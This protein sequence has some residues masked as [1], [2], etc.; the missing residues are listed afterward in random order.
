MLLH[1][2]HHDASTSTS[3]DTCRRRFADPAGSS[4][5]KS[6]QKDR[7][8]CSSDGGHGHCSRRVSWPSRPARSSAVT[9]IAVAG[10]QIPRSHRQDAAAAARRA[11]RA[12][13]VPLEGVKFDNGGDEASNATLDEL[14]L[15]R[16][17]TRLTMSW[18]VAAEA[19][20]TPDRPADGAG[21]P[22][23]LRRRD[24]A[25]TFRY[26]AI[27][28]YLLVSA[29][30]GGARP[31]AP[32]PAREDGRPLL[33]RP[34]LIPGE[35][36]CFAQVDGVLGAPLENDRA[37]R[38][39]ATTRP[40]PR[41]R[42]PRSAH[43]GLRR[44]T[45]AIREPRQPSSAR[46][47]ASRPRPPK[48]PPPRRPRRRRPPRR[49]PSY[50][51]PPSRRRPPSAPVEVE[52]AVAVAGVTVVPSAAGDRSAHRRARAARHVPDRARRGARCWSCGPRPGA[53]TTS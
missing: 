45:G 5:N 29:S 32:G 10:A 47:T 38:T 1:S 50:R 44:H 30:C 43:R 23:R 6:A 52:P 34:C 27:D 18:S 28:Q 9:G 51:R 40:A 11:A 41:R 24:R 15:A 53:C 4:D 17:V 2:V 33:A 8:T 19:A 31:P 3:T 42:R 7:K 20:P 16:P 13:P 25:T 46:S 26:G 39:R 22:R 36:A 49:L 48:R 14:N 35:D 21:D 12:V 37:R